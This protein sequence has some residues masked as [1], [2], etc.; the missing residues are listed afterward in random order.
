METQRRCPGIGLCDTNPI[1]VGVPQEARLLSAE[2]YMI[3]ALA[4]LPIN[5]LEP[6]KTL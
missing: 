4:P 6:N 3:G 1:G 5:I 2:P